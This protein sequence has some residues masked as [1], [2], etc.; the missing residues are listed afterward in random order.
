MGTV[1]GARDMTV[2][3]TDQDPSSHP[4]DILVGAGGYHT[5]NKVINTQIRMSIKGTR[6]EQIVKGR[7]ERSPSVRERDPPGAEMRVET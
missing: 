7:G 4:A 1:P 2:Y 5:T 3:K 6:D